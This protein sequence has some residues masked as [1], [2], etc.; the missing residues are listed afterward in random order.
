MRIDT[1]NQEA[2]EEIGKDLQ[3]SSNPKKI[4]N[5]TK[6]TADMALRVSAL[7]FAVLLLC[8]VDLDSENIAGA[9]SVRQSCECP[10]VIDSVPWRRVS[11]FTVTDKGP[12]C[13]EIEIVLYLKTN[14]QACLNPNSKQGKRLQKCWKRIQND[15]ARRKGCLH[16]KRGRSK[17]RTQPT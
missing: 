14:K 13:N 12:L 6:K 2:R 3:L 17:K 10:N 4:T 5:Q 1:A 8:D 7:L 11:D 9:T 16:L 15:P